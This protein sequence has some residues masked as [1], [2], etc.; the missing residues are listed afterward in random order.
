MTRPQPKKPARVHVGVGVGVLLPNPPGLLSA[1]HRAVMP[2]GSWTALYTYT[3]THTRLL[4]GVE[5]LEQQECLLGSAFPTSSIM[6]P[7]VLKVIFEQFAFHSVWSMVC[8]SLLFVCV[9]AHFCNSFFLILCFF[10][11]LGTLGSGWGSRHQPR[12]C[13]LSWG[14]YFKGETSDLCGSLRFQY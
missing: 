12:S 1:I 10:W 6:A 4:R 11:K 9:C 7:L 5:A 13:D 2:I 14:S 8:K 3:H